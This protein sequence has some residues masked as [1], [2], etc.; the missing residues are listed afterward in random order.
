MMN[1][2]YQSL[3]NGNITQLSVARQGDAKSI[4][5]VSWSHVLQP[6]ALHYFSRTTPCQSA[7]LQRCVLFQLSHG[8]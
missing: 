4:P 7:G 2:N 3:L 8:E 6:V 5:A 1:T